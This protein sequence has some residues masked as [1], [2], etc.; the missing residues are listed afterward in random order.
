MGGLTMRKRLM[1]VIRAFLAG[2]TR[3]ALG[4]WALG[5]R[6]LHVP[7]EIQF[8]QGAVE[9]VFPS[10]G[11]GRTSAARRGR[12]LFLAHLIEQSQGLEQRRHPPL[13]GLVAE[14]M[15]IAA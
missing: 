14:V 13:A 5:R 10:V 4:R 1:A 12:L 8:L 6:L 11:L 9:P 15:T 7:G 2:P 3:G